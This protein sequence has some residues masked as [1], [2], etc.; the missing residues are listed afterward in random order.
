MPWKSANTMNQG[1]TYSFF[2]CLDLRMM[3]KNA[4][5]ET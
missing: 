4:T 1:L 5:S 2:C 3:K